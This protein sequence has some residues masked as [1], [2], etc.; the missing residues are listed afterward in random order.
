MQTHLGMLSEQGGDGFGFVRREVIGDEM[1]LFA[2]WLGRDELAQ[3]SDKLGAG[4]A[5]GSLTRSIQSSI[6]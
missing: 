6:R 5:G 1:D 3:E 4:M 2:F